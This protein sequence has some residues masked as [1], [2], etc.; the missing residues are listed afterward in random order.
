ML[1]FQAYG[2]IVQRPKRTPA[3]RG[4]GRETPAGGD[5]EAHLMLRVRADDPEAFE[6]LVARYWQPLVRLLGR[7]VG[8]QEDA[9]DLV[10]DVFLRVYQARKTYTV[11]SKFSTWL[12]TIAFNLARNACRARRRK[13]PLQVN[14]QKVD[15]LTPNRSLSPHRG[16][17]D[18]PMR[19]LEDAELAAVVRRAVEGLKGRQRLVMLLN[20]FEGMGHAEI[21][22]EIGMTPQAVKSLLSRARSKLRRSLAGYVGSDRGSPHSPEASAGQEFGFDQR[23][24]V[25]NP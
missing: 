25:V 16:S 4:D 10:Q 24:S 23:P 17:A 1:T 18:L 19:H 22:R 21:A 13:P 5:P 20:G 15:R 6:Q 11:Q 12:F 14:P 7:K 8:S 3:P 9:Q 2:P